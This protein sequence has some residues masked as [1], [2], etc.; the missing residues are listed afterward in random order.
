MDNIA[1]KPD[2]EQKIQLSICDNGIGIP[3]DPQK[4]N[5][6][7]LVIMQ[8]RSRHLSGDLSIANQETGGVCVNFSFEPAYLA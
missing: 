6:Y 8:E 3:D 4:L 2:S 7:G 5:H 1:L